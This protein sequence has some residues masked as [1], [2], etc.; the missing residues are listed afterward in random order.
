[1]EFRRI[2]DVAD[3]DRLLLAG[4]IAGETVNGY[5]DTDFRYLLTGFKPRYQLP[6]LA[7]HH[8]NRDALGFEE[9]ADV[10]LEVDQNLIQVGGRIN[11]VADLLKVVAVGAFGLE[12][13]RRGVSEPQAF[14]FHRHFSSRRV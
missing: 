10:I 6:R 4:G 3:I 13:R 8:E 7:V 5:R 12:V 1:M 9:M 11:P 2:I 14:R